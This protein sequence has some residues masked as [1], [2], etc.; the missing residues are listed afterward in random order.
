MIVGINLNNVHVLNVEDVIETLEKYRDTVKDG[1][2]V[3]S[4]HK[5]PFSRIQLRLVPVFY[6]E[7]A[8]VATLFSVEGYSEKEY[9][10]NEAV[11][12]K[13]LYVD[14]DGAFSFDE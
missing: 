1:K 9:E 6:S 3:K 10:T 8:S 2:L 5:I 12:T 13:S 11:E 14:G 7:F 4:P